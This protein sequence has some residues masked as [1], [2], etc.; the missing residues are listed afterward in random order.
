MHC[1]DWPAGL[2]PLYLRE[3]PEPAASVM[4]IHNLAF[5]GNFGAGLLG[6]L[7]LPPSAF[8]LHGVEFYGR[9]SFLK[10]G[11]VF[12]DAVTTVSPTYAAEIQTPELGCG[13]DGLL[14]HRRER[15][16]RNPERHRHVGLGSRRAT[17]ISRSAM[18]RARSS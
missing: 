4:T 7:Q 6:E 3:E 9:L 15:A 1:H 11:I 8:T 2:A 13:F 18:T 17:S 14:R 5:Q 16:H 12:A 10:A